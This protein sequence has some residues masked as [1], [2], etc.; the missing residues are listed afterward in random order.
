MSKSYVRSRAV[1]NTGL[2]LLQ[3]RLVLHRYV[4]SLFGYADFRGLR[5]K[6]HDLKEGWAEDGHSY[7]FRALEGLSGLQITPDRLAGYDLRIKGYVEELN[8]LR[9]PPVQLKYFQYLAVLFTEIYLDRL[10]NDKKPG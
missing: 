2:P 3:Q 5:E 7:F 9:T 6:L 8:R 1:S 10:F 4:C